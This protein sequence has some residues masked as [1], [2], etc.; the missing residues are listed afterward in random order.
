MSAAPLLSGGVRTGKGD[1]GRLWG[2]CRSRTTGDRSAVSPRGTRSLALFGSEES[3]DK[4]RACRQGGHD[5]A[6]RR[7]DAGL[8][9]TGRTR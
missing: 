5:A 1:G 9:P 8:M 4:G 7:S 6:G 3:A 2:G